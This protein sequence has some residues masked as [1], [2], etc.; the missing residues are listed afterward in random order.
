MR[1]RNIPHTLAPCASCSKRHKSSSD[2]GKAEQSIASTIAAVIFNSFQS[3][4][5]RSFWDWLAA[6]ASWHY[7][8]AKSFLGSS[9]FHSTSVVTFDMIYH[10]VR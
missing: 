5:L 9:P 8:T 10:S 4:E 6:A 3:V 7:E 1:D 2:R